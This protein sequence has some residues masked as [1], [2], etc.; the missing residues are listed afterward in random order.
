[1]PDDARPGAIDE[2]ADLLAVEL[3]LDRREEE[4]MDL[5]LSPMA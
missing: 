5:L 1:M 3:G 4:L 2:G